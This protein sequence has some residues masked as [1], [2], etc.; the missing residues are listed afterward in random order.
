MTTVMAR[1]RY[2]A[3][4]IDGSAIRGQIQAPS[5]N[6][7][8][9]QLA[10]QGMRVT[11]IAER[12]RFAEIEVTRQR[13]PLVEIMHFSRQMGTFLRAGVA[14]PEALENLREDTRTKRFAAVLG[15]LIEQ[16]TAGRSVAEAI[17]VHDDVFPPYFI[18]MLGSAEFTGRLDD[19]FDRLHTYL[20][21]DLELSRQVRKALIYPAILLVVAIA[22][23]VMIV[24]FVIPKFADFYAGFT[25]K[26]GG[27]PELPLP[28][29]M[30]IA[31]S[32]FV[33]SGWGVATLVAA[34]VTSVA[35]FVWTRGDRGRRALDG[36]LLRL[37]LIGTVVTYS[38]TERF[39]RVLSVLLGAGVS[40]PQALPTAI[41]CSD[42]AVFRE[43]LTA[44]TDEVLSGAGFAEPIRDTG[45]FPKPVVQMVRVGERTGELADQLANAASFYEDEVSYS[46]EKLT[47]WLEPLVLVFIG[48]V[49]GFVALSMVSAMY[50][51]YNQV[52]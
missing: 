15:D 3:E 6:A 16:V 50:G 11:R 7:A 39:S 27:T 18:A 10:V 26:D 28:T 42:N 52:Q 22:V 29:R 23:S 5:A 1:F 21:R 24:V 17:A 51:I 2:E 25:T 14:L 47:Q 34:V 43:R 41:E 44:A 33:Q 9:N 30:L 37:P 45:L 49:V 4:T 35:A 38:A 13:V 8:R 40:L 46:V 12:K 36:L 32:D 20:K 48:I 19:A 31:I